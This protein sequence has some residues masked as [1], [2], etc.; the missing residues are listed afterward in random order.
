MIELKVNFNGCPR[1]LT[2]S[3]IDENFAISQKKFYNKLGYHVDVIYTI[4]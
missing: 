1:I 2:F 3:D 4:K